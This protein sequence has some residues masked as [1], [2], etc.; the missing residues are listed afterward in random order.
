MEIEIKDEQMKLFKL[1]TGEA[2][3]KSLAA[4]AHSSERRED[5]MRLFDGDLPMS[6]MSKRQYGEWLLS[7]REHDQFLNRFCEKLSI[8]EVINEKN[9]PTLF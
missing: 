2:H 8:E 5:I 9:N 3:G 6:I 7:L 4:L 1:K